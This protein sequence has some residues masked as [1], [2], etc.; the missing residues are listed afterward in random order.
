[1]LNVLEISRMTNHNGPGLRTLVHFKGCP[2]KCKWCST[3]ES[4]ETGDALGLNIDRCIGCFAC[5]AVCKTGALTPGTDGKVKMDWNRCTTCFACL[6][7]CYP[8]A[9]KKYGTPMCVEM[10]TKE[11]EKDSLFF[12]NSGGGVTFSGGEP[13]MYVDAE[14]EELYQRVKASGITIG[15]DTTGCVPWN[16]IERL[17]PYID[18]FLWDLKHMDSAVHEEVTG[19]PNEQI[20]ANLKKVDAETDIALHIRLP[21]IPG[22]TFSEENI[23][24]TCE[25]VRELKH[26]HRVELVPFHHMGKKRYLYSGKEYLMEDQELL[27][28]EELYK[29]KE[30]VES[31]GLPCC[32]NH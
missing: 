16:H 29:A 9:L 8:R 14:M 32:I 1:M 19:V 3:P 30:I 25:F 2:L 26:L 24:K 22:M 27:S 5:T 31:Y 12:K 15:V 4:Q 11:I 20:L 17:A 28:E 23:R 10:L 6:D 7:E 21:L 13:L 18:F